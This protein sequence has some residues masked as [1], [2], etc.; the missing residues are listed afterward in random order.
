V[1]ALGHHRQLPRAEHPTQ[2][3]T[4]HQCRGETFC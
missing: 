1:L 3:P 2:M 4:H